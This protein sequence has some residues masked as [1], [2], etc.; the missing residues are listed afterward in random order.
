MLREK[1]GPGSS[2]IDFLFGVDCCRLDIK[3]DIDPLLAESGKLSFDAMDWFRVWYSNEVKDLGIKI[4]IPFF[5]DLLK[6]WVSAGN[7]E[8]HSSIE[9]F[10]RTKAGLKGKGSIL[11]VPIVGYNHWSV[12]AMSDDFFLHFDS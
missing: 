11:I 4:C 10:C 3:R 9:R 5:N 2:T 6:D 7:G 12:A 1:G 8:S